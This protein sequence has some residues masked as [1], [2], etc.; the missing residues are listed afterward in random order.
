MTAVIFSYPPEIPTQARTM[1]TRPTTQHEIALVMPDWYQ[2]LFEL[3]EGILETP[4][5][6]NH[7]NF[8]NFICKNLDEPVKFPQNY[9]PDGILTAFPEAWVKDSWIKDCD[10]PFV[11]VFP[12]ND[13]KIHSVTVDSK[14]LAKTVVNHFVTLGFQEIGVLYTRNLEAS[15]D[16]NHEILT[17]AE[18]LKIPAWFCAVDDGIYPRDWSEFEDSAPK[19]KERLLNADCR[20]G[21]YTYHDMRG[22][23]FADYCLHLGLD[24]PRQIGVLGRFDSVNARLCNPELSSVVMPAKEMGQQAIHM[25]AQLIDGETPPVKK[26]YIPVG[27]VRARHSTLGLEDK[28]LLVLSARTMIREKACQGVTVDELITELPIARS[29]FE[30]RFR[31]ITGVSPAQEMRRVRLEKAREL[32][33]TTNMTLE[34]IAHNIGF[35]DP[36]PFVVFFKRESGETPGQYRSN[37]S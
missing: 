32:L 18:R 20:L 22:R 10:I 5:V 31:A 26:A 3:V 15:E 19:L 14:T 25:L 12:G 37:H 30:K 11:N 16:L 2:F 13:P 9:K 28:D 6:R 21:V 7:C 8:R 4:T 23:I 35:T 1:D 34:D 29:T 24:I 27:E 17:E 33:I 36:R